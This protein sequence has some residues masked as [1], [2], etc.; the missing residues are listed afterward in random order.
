M[1][2][3]LLA[4]LG[5]SLLVSAGLAASFPLAAA[6]SVGPAGT[7]SLSVHKAYIGTPS[8][9]CTGTEICERISSEF[10]RGVPPRPASGF[11]GAV[12][13]SL[14]LLNDSTLA[15]PSRQP[16]CAGPQAGVFDPITGYIL[17]ACYAGT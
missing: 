4:I 6:R 14:D 2:K 12:N 17:V 7:S 13:R 8:A 10:P 3:R 16:E 1:R 11:L 9:D 15:G 5:V